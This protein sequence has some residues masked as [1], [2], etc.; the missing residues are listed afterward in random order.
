MAKKNIKVQDTETYQVQITLLQFAS[1]ILS[2]LKP[3]MCVCV[4]VCVAEVLYGRLKY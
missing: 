2:P 1:V 4:C 3:V